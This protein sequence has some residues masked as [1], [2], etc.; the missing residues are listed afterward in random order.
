MMHAYIACM[1]TSRL[2]HLDHELVRYRIAERPLDSLA[3]NGIPS[4]G[5]Q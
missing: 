4:L 5:L 1:H 2:F 3:D